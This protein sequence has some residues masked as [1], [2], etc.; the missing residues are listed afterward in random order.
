M[1][2][3]AVADDGGTDFAETVREILNHGA[4]A[5]MLSIGHRTGLFDVLGSMAPA[6][7]EA[8]AREAG[9]DERYVRE[10]LSALVAG[11]IV[12]LDEVTHFYELPPA[13]AAVLTRRTGAANLAVAAQW[14]PLLAAVED[15][16]VDAFAT[17]GGVPA[18]CYRRFQ[19]LM[20]EDTAGRIATRL[21]SH[22]LP[23]VPGMSAA[24]ERGASLL[25]VGCGAGRLLIE[26]AERFPRS[27]FRGLDLSLDAI[28]EARRGAAERSLRNV[29]FEIVDVADL[30]E[31]RRFHFATA[32]GVLHRLP[33]PHATLGQI[34]KALKPGGALLLHEEA[35]TGSPAQD[36]ASPLAAFGYTLSCLHSLATARSAG[37]EP[38]GAMWG[39]AAARS[40]LAAAGFRAIEI[41]H[42]A[43]DPRSMFL[44]ARVRSA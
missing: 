15:E 35:S 26:L 28:S 16:V 25:D 8:I 2:G 11:G 39:A 33:D 19:K 1:Q 10:W 3:L 22:V 42:I 17:G 13:H 23:L 34:A 12:R 30:A 20:S 36:A 32:F 5:L 9:L 14:I 29:R 24:L 6:R 37:G 43:D 38:L 31:T 41:K 4:L 40:A 27:R 21:A 7:A 44:V 18:G